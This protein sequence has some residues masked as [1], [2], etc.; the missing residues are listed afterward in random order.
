MCLTKQS[1]NQLTQLHNEL[2]RQRAARLDILVDSSKLSTCV[3]D[4]GDL[5]LRIEGPRDTE[6]YDI[7]EVAHMQISQ[8]LGIPKTYYDKMLLEAPYLLSRNINHWLQV[9]EDTRLIRTLDGT[10]R[11]FLSNKYRRLDL[12]ELFESIEKPLKDLKDLDVQIA[13]LTDTHMYIKILSKRL[14]AN[15]GV[16]DIVQQGFCISSSELG[17][18]AIKIEQYTYRRQSSNGLIGCSADIAMKKLHLGVEQLPYAGYKV[19]PNSEDMSPNDIKYFDTVKDTVS[20]IADEAA[21]NTTITK[22]KSLKELP[23]LINPYEAVD[24]LKDRFL[25]TEAERAII[26]H[27]Y[28]RAGE[29]TAFGLS[30]AINR[31]AQDLQSYN[32]QIELERIAG[33]FVDFAYGFAQKDIKCLPLVA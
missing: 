9:S 32:R 6:L 4:Y 13:R 21:F 8:K 20:K 15:I 2:K 29:M 16:G 26:L 11:A 18:G 10:A 33:R 22:L 3:A 27:H 30:Q 28:M 23:I 7:T 12:L 14:K 31:G 1:L 24:S 19:L 25:V 5:K 17:L